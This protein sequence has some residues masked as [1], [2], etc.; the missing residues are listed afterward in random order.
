METYKI[1]VRGFFEAM[2]SREI[3]KMRDKV[4]EEVCLDFPGLKLVEGKRKVLVFINT[5]LRKYKKLNFEI[6]E[7]LVDG[8]RA[9]AIWNNSGITLEDKDYTNNGLTYFRFTNDKIEFISDYFKDTSFT[10]N[11]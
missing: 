11:N 8:D 4:C 1:L 6:L 10:K 3:E 7:I 5:L 2:N 9:C